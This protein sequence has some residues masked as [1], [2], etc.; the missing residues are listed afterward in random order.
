[1]P[2]LIDEQTQFIDETTNTPIV[3]GSVYIGTQ[4]LNPKTN[5]ITIYSDRDLT[6]AI[7]NP[8]TTDSA[9]RTTNKIW[10]P[11]KYSIQVDDSSGTQKY[12][13]LDAGDTSQT[14]ISVLDSVQGTNTITA[15]GDPTISTLVDGQQYNFRA[16]NANTGAVTLQIDLTSA[17]AIKKFHDV[18]LVSGDIEADQIVSVIYNATDDV[19]EMVSMPINVSADLVAIKSSDES[20][21]NNTI[22]DDNDLVV[23]LDASSYYEFNCYFEIESASATPGFKY[24]W[25]EADGTYDIRHT[26][27]TSGLDSNSR[28]TE[29][30]AVANI[31]LGA[32]TPTHFIGQGIVR[33]AGAGGTFKI[34]W[35]QQVTDANAVIMRAGSWV[36]LTKLA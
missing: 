24:Q 22:Q 28:V 34:Q 6:T 35:A 4:N 33:T 16:A 3:G 26:L 12:Q 10:V 8:Q 31:S 36:R 13:S 25:V 23:T 19:F 5:T 15:E 29:A 17:K 9:G 21:T 27:W 14:G 7:T 18:A 11:G 2:S 30:S 32:A 1:M 20:V